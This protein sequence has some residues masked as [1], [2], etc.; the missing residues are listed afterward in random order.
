MQPIR[1][2]V[3]VVI[4]RAVMHACCGLQEVLRDPVVCDDGFSYERTAV[5]Q[6]LTNHQTSFVTGE[7]L[8]TKGLVPYRALKSRPQDS[9]LVS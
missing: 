7:L 6:W 8:A 2:Y 3:Y 5:V 4:T 1:I 9:A